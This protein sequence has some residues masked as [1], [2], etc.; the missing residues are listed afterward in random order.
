MIAITEWTDAKQTPPQTNY[1]IRV[2]YADG[3]ECDARRIGG[4]VYIPEGSTMYR[5]VD[6]VKWRFIDG[7]EG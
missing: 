7:G 5:Y 2:L 1:K 3:M 4:K 6:V